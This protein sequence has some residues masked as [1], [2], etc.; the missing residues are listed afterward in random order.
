MNKFPFAGRT[1]WSQEINALN[2]KL[3]ELQAARTAVMDLTASNPTSCGFVY[4]RGLLEPLSSTENFNYQP[5]S[6]GLLQARQAVSRYYAPQASLPPGQ[7]ILTASTSEAYSFLMRLLVNPGE[8]VL[9]PRP[10]YPLFQFL[11]EIND[12]RFDHYPLVYDGRWRMDMDA[13]EGLVDSHTRAV[14]LVNPNNPTGSY[15]SRAELNTLNKICR[16]HQLSIIS[17]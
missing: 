3:E 6:C 5:D 17:D 7:I 1:D 8:K 16:K 9:I 10:S 14:I 2:K 12:V 4:P 13:L 11:L 15:I